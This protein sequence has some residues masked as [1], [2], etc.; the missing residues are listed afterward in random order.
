MFKRLIIAVIV[1]GI[2]V[3][4]IV[5]FKFF[6]DGMMAQFL[7]GM[8]PPPVPVTT[9]TVEPVTWQPGIDAVGT[10]LAARG[11]DLAIESGGLVREIL[12]T[13]NDAVTEGQPLVQIDDD[14][15]K[16]ALAAAQAGLGVAQTELRRTE[17]LTARGVN[18][19]NTV[20]SA[21][22][23]TETAVAEVAQVQ[24]ALDSK[25]MTA[26][27]AGIIGIPRIE[28]GQYV[29][30]GTIFATLQDLSQ[31]QVDFAVPEQQ[32]SALAL[33]REITV[34]TEVGDFSA[35]GRIIA[36]E[37]R[38][39]PNSRLVSVRAEVDNVEGNIYPG[40][41]LRVRIALPAEEGVIALPQTAV[42]STLY[43]DSIYVVQPGEAEGDLVVDQ[44]FVKIGRRSGARIEIVEG[45]EAGQRIVTSGQNRLTDGAKVAVDESVILDAPA[46]E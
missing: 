10:A 36:I 13:A 24:T 29:T 15:E 30:P 19:A 32:I 38:I 34:S 16:A 41:F 26:P 4:G 46:G 23:Q 17:T 5:W 6:R 18:A 45:I 31:M 11:V 37:P 43:G 35:K 12:F 44:V 1:L 39:D 40:Q 2:V 8:V 42:S 14:S 3:G 21:E 22:A 20:E 9:E 25:R 7:S 33:G 27:F 28:L